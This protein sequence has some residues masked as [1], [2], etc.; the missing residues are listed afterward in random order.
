MVSGGIDEQQRAVQGLTI[1]K[2]LPYVITYVCQKF[3]VRDKRGQI[4]KSIYQASYHLP[5]DF[6]NNF[7]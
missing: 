3:G 6:Q 7:F 4:P 2:I 5:S 1:T